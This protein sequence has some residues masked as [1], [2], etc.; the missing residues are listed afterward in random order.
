MLLP[1][2]PHPLS[3][4]KIPMQIQYF[5][6]VPF[7]GL[8]KIEEWANSKGHSLKKTAFF[9]DFKQPDWENIHWLIVMGG[10]MSTDEL[11]LH[12]WLKQ[13][14][15]WIEQ[16]LHRGIKVLG[17]CL[18]AQLI[19]DVLGAK[20]YPNQNKEIGWHSVTMTEAGCKDLLFSSF[21]QTFTVFQWHGDT[22]TAPAGT[23]HLVQSPYCAGQAFNYQNQAWGLQFHLE[24]NTNTIQELLKHCANDLAPGPSVQSQEEILSLQSYWLP[25]INQNMLDLLN[26]LELNTTFKPHD[27]IL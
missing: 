2:A 10:P 13:E 14:K 27:P 3:G 24:I 15:I 6:H 8:G 7:E 23:T 17:I 18:G 1:L 9:T 16:A 5:Q 25:R 22:F 12:P 26:H 19:A 20:V 21:P 4:Y 11:A